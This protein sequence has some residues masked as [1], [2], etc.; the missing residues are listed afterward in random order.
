MDRYEGDHGKVYHGTEA[1]EQRNFD[2]TRATFA[3]AAGFLAAIA[4]KFYH[5][6]GGFFVAGG[7]VVF[8]LWLIG[9]K[10]LSLGLSTPRI[11]LAGIIVGAVMGLTVQIFAVIFK[12]EKTGYLLLLPFVPVII[13]SLYGTFSSNKDFPTINTTIDSS[14]VRFFTNPYTETRVESNWTG[15]SIGIHVYGFTNDGW[16]FTSRG[17]ARSNLIKFNNT[18][19]AATEADSTG[20]GLVQWINNFAERLGYSGE[21]YSEPASLQTGRPVTNTLVMHS[22]PLQLS[23]IVALVNRNDVVA[24]AGEERDGF[25]PILFA[26]QGYGLNIIEGYALAEHINIGAE[27]KSVPIA[28]SGR[29]ATVNTDNRAM[30]SSKHTSHDHFNLIKILN[31]G[32]RV[33][34]LEEADKNGW[35]KVWFDGQEGFAG[36]RSLD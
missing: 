7:A 16:A 8:T 6:F 35:V 13:I 31:K 32:D 21:G 11:V 36:S 5:F 26:E 14:Q 15:S 22:H 12:N 28:P 18:S 10:D 27:R 3:N 24:V 34:V 25:L 1:T 30:R 4:E 23:R 17:W 20:N 9:M 33:V 19:N 2:K 29:T